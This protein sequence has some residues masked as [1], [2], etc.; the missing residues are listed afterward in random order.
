MNPDPIAALLDTLADMQARVA[1]QADR[2]ALRQIVGADTGEMLTG[3]PASARALLIGAQ[4][5]GR[6][7]AL[8]RD[9]PLASILLLSHAGRPIGLLIL[10]WPSTGPVTLVDL[11]LLPELRRRGHGT[12]ALSALCAVADRFGR[13][14]RAR[15]FYDNPAHRLLD[16]TGFVPVGGT[17]LDIVKER[18]PVNLPLTC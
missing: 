17:V 2:A 10:D 6:L 9:H 7:S 5:E 16:R 4:V 11:T 3:V 15:L 18:A 1:G 8:M 13:S 14:L 12:S